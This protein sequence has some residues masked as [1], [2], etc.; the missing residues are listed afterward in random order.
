MELSFPVGDVG[1]PNS[2]VGGFYA[3]RT[4]GYVIEARKDP[5]IIRE[6]DEENFLYA[7]NSV[8]HPKTRT[9]FF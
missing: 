1:F 4:Y 8:I 6:A 9:F 3:D 2:T 5:V 7:N